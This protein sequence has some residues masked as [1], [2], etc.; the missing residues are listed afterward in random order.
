[1]SAIISDG[2]T[3]APLIDL[4]RPRAS[5][6]GDVRRFFPMLQTVLDRGDAASYGPQVLA[7]R[8][9][10]FDARVPSVLLGVVLDDE[11]MPNV[12]SYTLA[13]SIGVPVVEPLLRAEPGLALARI[14]DPY[15]EIGLPHAR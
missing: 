8:L 1:M 11:I 3:F 12:A 9:P 15:A 4:L 5:S 14:R 10:V 6:R 2:A 13:R 7:D